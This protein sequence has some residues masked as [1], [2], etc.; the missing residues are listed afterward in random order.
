[1]QELLANQQEL[2]GHLGIN[3]L[4]LKDLEAKGIISKASQTGA[5]K[6]DLRRNTQ[7]YVEHLRGAV[8]AGGKNYTEAKTELAEAQKDKYELDNAVTRG[9]LITVDDA[10]QEYGHHLVGVRQSLMALGGKLAPQ[11]FG[12]Q[13]VA[14]A[15][16]IIDREVRA[17]FADAIAVLEEVASPDGVAAESD[18]ERVGG[19]EPAAVD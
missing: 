9:E 17:I 7:A 13:S 1:M 4:T 11:L 10:V 12:T 19:S 3:R 5:R 18:G 8:R 14:E 6:Y 15:K 2:A 16:A